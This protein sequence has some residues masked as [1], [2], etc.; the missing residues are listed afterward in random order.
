MVLKTLA[1][2]LF[3]H[4]LW[5]LTQESSTDMS[6]V[7]FSNSCC[8]LAGTCSLLCFKIYKKIVSDDCLEKH[9]SIMQ[10]SVSHCN[11]F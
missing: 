2:S 8:H 7:S 4:L 6:N 1:N 10:L 9:V 5:L 11:S 3:N